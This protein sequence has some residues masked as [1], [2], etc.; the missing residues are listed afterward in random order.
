MQAPNLVYND[1]GALLLQQQS[2]FKKMG[3]EAL[4][5][6]PTGAWDPGPK[7]PPTALPDPPKGSPGPPRADPELHR[8]SQGRQSFPEPLLGGSSA[9]KYRACAQNQAAQNTPGLPAKAVAAT[10]ART[11]LPHAPGARMM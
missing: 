6:G 5:P 7:G 4:G 1:S 2:P 8:A 10:A 9:L 3:P 11:P